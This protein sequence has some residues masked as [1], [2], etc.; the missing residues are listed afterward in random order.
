MPWSG[1]RR[2]A[3]ASPNVEQRVA[4]ASKICVIARDTRKISTTPQYA[5][6]GVGAFNASVS[7]KPQSNPSASQTE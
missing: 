2:R 1:L 4:V 7:A 3:V 6:A 5:G